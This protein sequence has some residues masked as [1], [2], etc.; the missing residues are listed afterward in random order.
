MLSVPT[1]DV[2]EN[3]KVY[4]SCVQLNNPKGTDQFIA[5]FIERD[6]SKD[7]GHINMIDLGA[8]I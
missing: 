4:R 3:I 2:L 5:K 7:D 1:N 6:H 8:D